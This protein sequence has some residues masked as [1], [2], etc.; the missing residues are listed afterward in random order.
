MNTINLNEAKELLGEIAYNG[1]IERIDNGF[2]FI[3]VADFSGTC[4]EAHIT[5]T[6]IECCIRTYGN[7]RNEG[8]QVMARQF[9]A[10]NL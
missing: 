3:T 5:D 7:V 4:R 10:E 2:K 8:T 1:S 9:V 6:Q